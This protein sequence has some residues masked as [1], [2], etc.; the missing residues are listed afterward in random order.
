LLNLNDIK[1]LTSNSDGRVFSLYLNVD[2]SLP[3]NQAT[4][5]AWRIFVKN[6]L[7]ETA[8]AVSESDQP[9]WVDI[10]KRVEAYFETYSPTSRGLALFYGT[11]LQTVYELPVPPHQNEHYFGDV[12]IAPLLWLIDEYE[13]YL[14]VLVDREEAQL[15]TTY[16]GDTSRQEA[17]ASDRFSFDFKEK[18]MMPRPSGPQADAGGAITGGS[19]KDAFADKMDDYVAKFH[20]D[21]AQRV[22]NWLKTHGAQ[23]V[24]IGGDEKSAHAVHDEL[25]DAVLPHVVTVMSIPFQESDNQVMKRILPIALDYEREKE[26]ETVRTV[27]GLA[28]TEGGR[29]VVGYEAVEQAVQMQQVD[30][31]IAPWPLDDAARFHTLTVQAFTHGNATIELVHGEAADLLRAEGGIAARLFYAIDS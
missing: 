24:I 20:Q 6:A 12:N 4:Q 3:E 29:G 22:R 16:L 7:K 28:K 9:A 10:S 8:E 27:V 25:H 13:Q 1:T 31:L 11:D 30:L 19:Q 17:M 23:R 26:L 18:T 15:L 14:I 5:P 2:N 21:V